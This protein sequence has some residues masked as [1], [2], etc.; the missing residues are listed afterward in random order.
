MGAMMQRLALICSLSI[1]SVAS[2]AQR[3]TL[4]ALAKTIAEGEGRE[5]YEAF[6]AISEYAN[7][8]AKQ[9]NAFIEMSGYL[10]Q[11][12][13]H[14]VVPDFYPPLNRARAKQ[15]SYAELAQNAIMEL[16]EPARHG[17]VE[18]LNS[19]QHPLA[20]HAALILCVIQDSALQTQGRPGLAGFR[21][22]DPTE[23]KPLETFLQ[24]QGNR[25]S[26]YN[27]TRFVRAQFPAALPS[28]HQRL[29]D[30]QDLQEKREAA[31]CLGAYG[32]SPALDD[33]LR[34]LNDHSDA[35]L[36][37]LVA[38]QLPKFAE[39]ERTLKALSIVLSKETNEN[40]RTSCRIASDEIRS[41]QQLQK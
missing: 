38:G 30:T 16:G 23:R 27:L 34:I 35:H 37:Q 11:F 3:V 7:T 39:S 41:K 29:K 9:T 18:S 1:C 21:P 22:L 32:Y 31:S 5:V 15:F 24:Q 13:K 17:L 4:E 20:D 10:G 28:V 6:N 14:C 8:R 19:K 36:R 33:L 12:D 2:G 25:L 26:I 40:V